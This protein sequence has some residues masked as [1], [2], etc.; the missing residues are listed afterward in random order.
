MQIPSTGESQTQ[1]LV[2]QIHSA[3]VSASSTV[4]Q[5]SRSRPHSIDGV[6]VV[7]GQ[8]DKIQSLV[9]RL[10]DE[11]SSREELVKEVRS[12]LEQGEYATRDAAAR[13]AARILGQEATT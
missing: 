6:D 11:P 5:S 7:G 3:H 1:G 8:A 13:T 12:R 2:R 10:K 4:G 9:A